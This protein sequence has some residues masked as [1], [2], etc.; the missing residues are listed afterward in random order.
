MK[1]IDWQPNRIAISASG[2]GLLVLSEVDY[3]GWALKVDGEKRPIQ[4]VAGL[5]RGVEL[6]PGEHQVVFSYFPIEL[7]LGLAA[8]LI[9]LLWLLLAWRLRKVKEAKQA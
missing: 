8:Q 5:L 2:P 3:S 7:Q 9:C 1:S 6:G 4:R